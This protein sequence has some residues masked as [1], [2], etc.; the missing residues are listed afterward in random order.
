MVQP[1]VEPLHVNIADCF[2]CRLFANKTMS[3]ERVLNC[4]IVTAF[5]LNTCRLRV[6]L[7]VR[8]VEAAIACAAFANK[9]PLDEPEAHWIPLI[10]GSLAE[11]YIEPMLPHVGD[12]DVMFHYSTDLAIPRGQSP[13][14]QLPAEFHNCVYVA[15]IIDSHLPGYVYLELRYLLAEC[16]DEGKYIAVEYGTPMYVSNRYTYVEDS[17][18]QGPAFVHVQGNIHLSHDIVRCIRC[19]SWPPQAADW[20]TRHRNYDWP[21]SATVDRVVNNGCDVVH[22]AHRQCRHHELLRQAQWRLSFSRAE[23]VLLNSWMPVQQI[24]YHMLRV[25]MKAERLTDSADNSGAGRLSNYHIKTLMLWACEL[26]SNS[27]WTHDLNLVRI[28]VQVLY[29]LAEWLTESRCPHYFVKNCNLIDSSFNMNNLHVDQLMSTD[30][31]WLSTWFVDNYIRKCSQRCPHYI[32]R[33]FDDVSTSMKLQKAGSAIV[34]WRLNN[35]LLQSWLNFEFAERAIASNAYQIVNARSCI[36]S[37]YEF[38]KIDSRL[39]DYFTAVSFLRI[40]SKL[41]LHG[42]NDELMDI[43]ASVLGHFI[44]LRCYSNISTSKQSLIQSTKLMKVVANNSRSTVHLIEIEL[45]KAYLYRAL[46][47][48]DSDSDTIY[49]LANVYLAVLYYT[50]GQYQT[51]IDHCTLVTRSQDHSQCSSHV[52]QGEPLPKIDDNIDTVLGLIVFYRHVRTSALNQQVMHYVTDFNT[53]LFAYFLSIKCRLLTQTLPLTDKYRQYKICFHNSLQLFIGDVLLFALACRSLKEKFHDHYQY[54]VLNSTER[55]TSDLVELLQQSAVEH[56][57]TVRQ[58]EARE[59]GSVVAIVRTDFEALYAYKRGDYQRCLQLS[60]LNVHTLL[61]ADSLPNFPTFS[62]F[63]YLLDDDIVSLTAL[64]FIVNSKRIFKYAAEDAFISQLTLSLYLMTQCQL[65]LRHSVTS[66]VQTLNYIRV[67]QRKMPIN[68]T[69]DHLT[70][71]LNER[72]VLRHLH[73]RVSS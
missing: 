43:M 61:Y 44:V 62:E 55:R 69:L 68:R 1:T 63:V 32:L 71:K 9:Q 14:T 39:S 41:P 29:N 72:Y 48:K 13:P 64:T 36:Y 60:T 42:F 58:F 6:R 31:T 40:A 51:A 23:I 20:P 25:F 57:I 56:L 26:K 18:I 30:E 10:T 11:F 45:S 38:T 73:N 49:C 54:L 12:I 5:M 28:C 2:F 27:W 15:E 66:L 37:I 35:S 65:K 59:Y 47:C 53:E 4:E 46:R 22:V 17:E 33:L 16:V 3:A 34:S 50:T 52:V 21:D 70:L 8:N 67:A 24:V 7:S 19:L